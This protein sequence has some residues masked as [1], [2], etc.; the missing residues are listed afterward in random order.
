MSLTSFYTAL[1]GL[2]NNSQAINVIG[3]NL[4]NMNTVAFKAGKASFSELLAGISGTSA[5]GNPIS[6]GLGSTLNGVI[7]MNTQ[8]TIAY[9]GRA[10]DAAINGNGFF[11]VSTGG[12]LGFTRSGQFQFDKSGMLLSAD[13]FQ[14]LGYPAVQGQIDTSASLAPI[15]IRKGQ[16]IQASATAN[17]SIFANL[18]AQAEDGSTFATSVTVYDSLG[19]PHAVKLTFTKTGARAWSWSAT[20]PATDAG[21]SAEDSPVEIGSGN[22]QFDGSG[23]ISGLASNPTLNLTGLSDGA[24]DLQVTFHL[25]D[26]AGKGTITGFAGA[27]AVSSTIQDG[28]AAT[29]LKDVSFDSDGVIIGLT[30]SGQLIPLAQLALADFPNVDGLEKFRGSTFVAFTSSGEPSIGVAGTGGRGSVAGGSLEQSNVDMAQEFVNLIVAQRAYQANSR[31]IAATDELY[32]DALNL[33]R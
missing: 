7:R 25:L 1:T 30:E 16:S 23:K 5:T 27:S 28:Y 29:I 31:V 13:G 32:Q 21:G 12:G 8:G 17:M 19:S 9:T 10:A 22:L 4:A 6:F 26:A 20:I 3:D 2:N 11:V 18:D 14:L 24:A 33:K 15:E